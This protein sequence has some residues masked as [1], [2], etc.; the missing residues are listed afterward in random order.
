MNSGRISLKELRDRIHSL[1]EDISQQTEDDKIEALKSLREEYARLEH[2]KKVVDE[3]SEE[4]KKHYFRIFKERNVYFVKLRSIES[5]V[6][7]KKHGD[8]DGFLKQVHQYLNQ[9]KV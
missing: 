7:D 2:V 5:Y 9:P 6:E 4:L 8:K 3:K 1:D